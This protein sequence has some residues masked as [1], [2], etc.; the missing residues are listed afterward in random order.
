MI[1]KEDSES[2]VIRVPVYEDTKNA[3][4][5]TDVWVLSFSPSAVGEQDASVSCA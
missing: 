2:G 4:S 5:E 1:G 3:S